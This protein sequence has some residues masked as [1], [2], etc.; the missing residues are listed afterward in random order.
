MRNAILLSL[1]LGVLAGGC[2]PMAKY[3][4]S[5]AYATSV[6]RELDA[7]KAALGAC[8][9]L[10]QQLARKLE[11]EK[12]RTEELTALVAELES[13]NSEL[14]GQLGELSSMVSDLGSRNRKE[15]EQK[16]ELEALIG[17]LQER[18]SA[19]QDSLSAAQGRIDALEDETA[20]LEDETAR[21]AAEAARLAA[22]KEQLEQRSQAYEDLVRELDSEIQEGQIT[23]TELSGKLTVS[24]SNA[25]LFDSGSI[26]LK[27]EGIDAIGRVAGV[28]ASVNDRSIQVE[29][30]TDNV[31]VRKGA[32]YRDNWDLSSLRAST[33]VG[34]LVDGGVDPLNIATLGFGEHHPV[35]ENETPE[36]RAAN[37]RTEIV[38]VPK[39][40]VVPVE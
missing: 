13:A 19:T 10:G 2:I 35:A 39:L 16:A 32:A 22:E 27:A 33:V 30:H 4:E 5:L 11:A 36:G 1:V 28:L 34:V 3:D 38:L 25:I 37:R 9:G 18:S 24:L 21:L 8:D 15:R 14:E 23:I 6:E 7:T 31:P 12:A 17:S 40:A 26:D 20:R 29:G